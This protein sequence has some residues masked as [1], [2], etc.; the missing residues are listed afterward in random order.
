MDLLIMVLLM[1]LWYRLTGV[2]TERR[3]RVRT[4]NGEWRCC[5]LE[6]TEHQEGIDRLGSNRI[7]QGK[8]HGLGYLLCAVHEKGQD[9]RSLGNLI[10][11][12][13]LMNYIMSLRVRARQ[14][15]FART[16]ESFIVKFVPESYPNCVSSTWGPIVLHFS[17][18]A[19]AT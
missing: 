13:R 15:E 11:C 2:G 10:L 9:K 4:R 5:H 17:T 8:Q 1:T 16:V 7:N 18:K 6:L 14:L 19:A 12:R 3:W